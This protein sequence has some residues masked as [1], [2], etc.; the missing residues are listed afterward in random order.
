MT[1]PWPVDFSLAAAG[2]LLAAP[3][4]S[5]DLPIEEKETI[6]QSFTL[7]ESAGIRWLK[8]DNVDGSLRVTGVP[9]NQ[10]EVVVERTV[11]AESREKVATALQDVRLAIEQKGSDVVATVDAPWRCRDGNYSGANYRGWRFYGYRVRHDFEV[12]VPASASVWLRT[13]NEGDIAVQG[14]EGRYDVENINGSIELVDAAGPGHVY[15]L[16]GKVRVLFARNPTADADFG[17]LNGS[18][19]VYFRSGLDAD[20]RFKTFN[21]AVYTDFDVTALPPEPPTSERRDGKFI[22]KSNR[23]TGA[24]VGRGGPVFRFDAFNGTIRV[25]E[26]VQ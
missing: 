23:F 10:V 13:V 4:R 14:V 3:Q 18:V 17:S 22:F 1:N 15:A 20:L 5:A 24:R 8:V 21:G 19:D 6:R 11:R 7:P 12:R 25:R 26:R 9:G 16:N 2:A